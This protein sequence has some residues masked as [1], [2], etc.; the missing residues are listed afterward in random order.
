MSEKS[1]YKGFNGFNTKTSAYGIFADIKRFQG[2]RNDILAS[3][4]IIDSFRREK[5]FYNRLT[6]KNRLVD[7]F[8]GLCGIR[9]DILASMS[10]IDSFRREKEFHNRLGLIDSFSGLYGIRNDIL[11][12]MSIIDSFRKYENTYDKLN[13]FQENNLKNSMSSIADLFEDIIEE[14]YDDVLYE[15]PEI[16]SIPNEL[17]SFS[18]PIRNLSMQQSYKILNYIICVIINIS[19]LHLTPE[20]LCIISLIALSLDLSISLFN[21]K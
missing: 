4:S 18:S 6:S 13:I 14:D 3:N 1:Y 15:V 8:S 7:S 11:A 16:E 19:S 10:I 17:R 12:S 21:E 5:E 2:I 9:N 20:Q